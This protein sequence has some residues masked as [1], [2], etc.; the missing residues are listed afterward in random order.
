[1]RITGVDRD[2]VTLVATVEELALISNSIL[3]AAEFIRHDDQYHALIGFEKEEAQRVL[4]NLLDEE[5]AWGLRQ[6]IARDSSGRLLSAKELA[7][8]GKNYREAPRR[9]RTPPG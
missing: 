7:E 1:M 2:E 3:N 9:E 4:R 8:I 6:V 5:T